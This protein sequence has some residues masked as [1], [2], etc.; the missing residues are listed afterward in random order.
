[1]GKNGLETEDTTQAFWDAPSLIHHIHASI[2][3]FKSIHRVIVL[4]SGKYLGFPRGPP[5]PLEVLL[6][7]LLLLA[8]LAWAVL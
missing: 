8:L 7:L 2:H 6:L 1:M 4:N 3:S 5:T